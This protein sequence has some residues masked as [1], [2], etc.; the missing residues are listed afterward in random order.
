[1]TSFRQVPTL[2]TVAFF[3]EINVTFKTVTV[4]F[5]GKVPTMK[6]ESGNTVFDTV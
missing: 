5:Y 4:S 6:G 2:E 3:D 1:M